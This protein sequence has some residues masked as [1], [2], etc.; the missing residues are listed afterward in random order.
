MDFKFQKYL[1][2]VF[3]PKVID[4]KLKIQCFSPS[5]WHTLSTPDSKIMLSPWPEIL[6]VCFEPPTSP[7]P[8]SYVSEGENPSTSL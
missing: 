5:V 3:D 1:E 6:F 7:N 4:L 8:S 2:E